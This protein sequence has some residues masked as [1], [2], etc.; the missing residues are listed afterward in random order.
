MKREES[1]LFQ[2]KQNRKENGTLMN[3]MTLSCEAVG[4]GTRHD[5]NATLP[6]GQHREA[7]VRVRKASCEGERGK[8]YAI[9][10]AGRSDLP[11]IA[12]SRLDQRRGM[13]GGGLGVPRG[14]AG[15]RCPQ[16]TNSFLCPPVCGIQQLFW[17][18][19]TSWV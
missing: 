18:C 11:V 3:L 10:R 8:K 15:L 9:T 2:E 16:T 19:E 1:I 5:S 6:V 17:N 4:A 13:G 14:Q 12:G 7:S